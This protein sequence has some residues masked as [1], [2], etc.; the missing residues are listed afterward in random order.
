M[1]LLPMDQPERLTAAG[2]LVAAPWPQRRPAVSVG[3]RFRPAVGLAR[4]AGAL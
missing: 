1:T 2:D 4:L 3:T